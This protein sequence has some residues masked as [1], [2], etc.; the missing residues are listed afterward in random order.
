LAE[1]IDQAL[2][3]LADL[4]PWLDRVYL[5]YADAVLPTCW[6]WH[7]EVVEELWWLRCAHAEAYHPEA[8]S[9]LRAGDWH[10]RQR[11]NL[12]RRIRTA[13]GSCELSEHQPERPA[14]HTPAGAPLTGAASLIAGWVAA[15]RPA[16][17]PAPT[18]GQ[19]AEAE[20]HHQRDL[21]RYRTRR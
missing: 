9:W 12:V 4:I 7:P 17:T 21:Q 6:L 3:L 19:L 20:Q 16:P 11:P 13:I 18:G 2:T 15:G 5:A 1:D 10:D 8:G 14:S